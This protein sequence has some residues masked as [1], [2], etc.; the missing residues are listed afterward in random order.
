MPFGIISA[1]E[2][3]HHAMDNMLEGLEGI[4]CYVDGVVIWGYTLQEHNE[5]I[6]VLQ[7]VRENGLKLNCAKC[8][9]A[10]LSAQGMEADEKR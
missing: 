9:C 5:R 4:H 10:K 8:H 1:S 6:K 7:R 2:I 3:C